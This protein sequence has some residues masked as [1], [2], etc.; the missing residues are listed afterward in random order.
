MMDPQERLFL[1]VAWHALEDAGWTRR[2]LARARRAEFSA[3]VGVFAGVTS[4]P[5]ALLGHPGG[6]HAAPTSL[7]WSLANRVSYLFN[8]NGP[9][10]PVD[11]ACS[12]SLT[13]IHLAVQAIRRGECQQAIAGGVNLYLH[14]SKFSHLSLMQML[15]RDGRCRAF[16]AGA[17]GFVPGEGCGVVLLKPLALALA[18]GDR[19][20]GVIRATAVNHGGRTNG[21]TVPSPAAQAELVGRALREGGVEPATVSCVEAHGTGTALGDPV[22]V[23]GLTR[24]F[25]GGRPA[26]PWCALGSVKTNIGHLESAAGIAGLTK[27]LLQ[28]RHRE[29]APSL[30][31]TPPNPR[32]DF[33]ATPFR[34]PHQAEPWVSAGPRRAPTQA[35]RSRNAPPPSWPATQGWLTTDFSKENGPPAFPARKARTTCSFS[36]ASMLQVE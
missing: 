8:F 32:I 36:S 26:T 25:T 11:T 6:G 23:E 12:S 30:H 33:A 31:A 16:G 4:N 27:V 3:N 5:Y 24:A 14:P 10:L 19:I 20:H 1:E 18:D 15:S 34:V 22:E 28:F 29:L 9:S 2:D 21:Y 13:A 35:F 17:D 7:P